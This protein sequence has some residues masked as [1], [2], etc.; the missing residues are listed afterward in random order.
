MI[1]FLI[2]RRARKLTNRANQQIT[3]TNVLLDARGTEMDPPDR[4]E[5]EMRLEQWASQ[6]QRS[7]VFSIGN[8]FPFILSAPLISG[9]A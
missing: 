9:M 7:Y 3:R 5:I 6:S 4:A 1:L 8:L 2:R